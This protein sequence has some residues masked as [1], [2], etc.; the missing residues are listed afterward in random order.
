[1]SETC[2]Q[3]EQAIKELF[4]KCQTPEQRYEQIIALGKEQQMLEE[5]QRKE[6][7]RVEGCQSTMLLHTHVEGGRIYFQTESDAL[8]SAG[9]G[10][11]MTRVYSG[12]L[13]EVVLKHPPKFL[14][15]LS[16]PQALSPSR[17]NGLASLHLNMQREA[18]QAIM[19]SPS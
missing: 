6:A 12:E 15:E 10:V 18:L 19:Q 7:K 9:L 4:A 13:P 8:I 17:A 14:E 5:T 11:I 2:K 1:M 3:K 16:I